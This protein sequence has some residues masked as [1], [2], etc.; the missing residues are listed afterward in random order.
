MGTQSCDLPDDSPPS[1]LW[2]DLQHNEKTKWFLCRMWNTCDLLISFS[3]IR[4]DVTHTHT[5]TPL[6]CL[7]FRIRKIN[8]IS[9]LFHFFTPHA[10]HPLLSP[11]PPPPPLAHITVSHLSAHHHSPSPCPCSPLDIFNYEIPSINV[12]LDSL[13]D[14]FSA[15]APCRKSLAVT[16]SPDGDDVCEEEPQSTTLWPMS[17]RH[18]C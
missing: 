12:N 8:I 17:L 11:S 2:S 6:S 15:G 16:D 14:E 7:E 3:Q 4:A 18:H 5:H 1:L 13:I 9:A 10:H